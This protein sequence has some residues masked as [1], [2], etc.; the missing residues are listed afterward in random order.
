MNTK[1]PWFKSS[2]SGDDGSDCVEIAPCLRAVHVRDSKR[3]NGP[4]LAVGAPAWAA[5]VT[6]ASAS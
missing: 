4:R 2:Y 3:T 5:F 6:Y 1:L